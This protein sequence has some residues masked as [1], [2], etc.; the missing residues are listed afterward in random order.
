MSIN[1]IVVTV[2]QLSRTSP[3]NW[4]RMPEDGRAGARY[5]GGLGLQPGALFI[6]GLVCLGLMACDS[7]SAQQADQSI[8]GGHA[9]WHYY[10]QHWKQPGTDT[11]CC[12]ARE[13]V[14]GGQE[15]GDCEPAVA[16]LRQ[17]EWYAWERHSQKWLK[18]PDAKIV[19]ERNPSHEEGHLCWT[20]WAGIICF[21][22]PDAGN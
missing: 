5:V 21:V 22:P 14:P 8:G 19:R 4:F 16:E 3:E 9:R 20:P 15:V 6:A 13:S 2:V 1:D 17:G 10:Y 11:S 12:N 7:A 18:V